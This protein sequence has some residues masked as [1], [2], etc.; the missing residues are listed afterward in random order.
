MVFLWAALG[1]TV[2]ADRAVILLRFVQ[3]GGE[4][5]R[6]ESERLH[7]RGGAHRERLRRRLTL[8]SGGQLLG[9]RFAPDVL[10]VYIGVDAGI[11]LLGGEKPDTSVVGLVLSILS[12]L[13]MPATAFAQHRTGRS[14]GSRAVVAAAVETWV[15]S[16]LSFALLAGIGLHLAFGWAWADPLAALAMLPVVIWQGFET[17]EEVSG[18]DE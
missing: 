12:L 2:A 16:Y 7:P 5:L 1:K 10:A 6:D 9:P 13:I 18:A 8:W 4:G 14:L 15:C 17:L 11:S 3:V